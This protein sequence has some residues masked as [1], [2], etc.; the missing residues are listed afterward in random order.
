MPVD[1]GPLCPICAGEGSLTR[2]YRKIYS[3]KSLLRCAVCGLYFVWPKP[4]HEV[5]KKIYEKEYYDAWSL[6]ALG[7]D[8]LG[9]IKN[10]TFSTILDNIARFKKPGKILDVGCAFGH[11]LMLAA[12]RG[13]NPYGIEFSNYAAAEVEKKIGK[14]KVWIGDFVG[15]PISEQSFDII[16]MV[17]VIEHEYEVGLFLNKA[18]KLLK[19]GGMVVILT[20][21]MDTLSRKV[22]RKLWPHFNQEHLV[23]FS[24]KSMDT[25][26]AKNGFRIVN[27]G[28]FKKAFNIRYLNSQIAT[29]G[30]GP[31]RALFGIFLFF[32]PKLFWNATFFMLHGEMLVIAEKPTGGRI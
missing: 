23:Y 20:P 29:H 9:K 8:G 6:A 11:L 14:D 32:V 27:I 5:I 1:P 12:E 31:L 22:L 15:L 19:P 24:R 21:D 17:D 25:V 16:T 10:S 2:I 28:S 3:D 13:W 7:Q 26:L 4:T 18:W 30:K